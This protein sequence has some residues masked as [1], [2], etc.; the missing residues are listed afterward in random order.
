M[1][2]RSFAQVVLLAVLS[3]VVTTGCGGRGRRGGSGGGGEVPRDSGI[4]TTTDAGGQNQDECET[5]GDRACTSSTT[6]EQCTNVGGTLRW[7]A[8]TCGANTT[9]QGGECVPTSSG[10]L[11]SQ[12]VC[13]RLRRVQCELIVSCCSSELDC[14]GAGAPSELYGSVSSCMTF[15]EGD[16][17][18]CPN[19]G[20]EYSERAVARCESD[21]VA[22]D[23][24]SYL[25]DETYPSSC[26]AAA[27]PL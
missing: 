25:V 6:F 27:T 19:D 20:N 10:N 24:T 3:L 5:P 15:V 14:A 2:H 11:N 22:Y 21:Y 7:T 18:A 8:Q 4:A 13:T 16:Q 9:C 26:D 12:Q 1:G 17:G 23:C